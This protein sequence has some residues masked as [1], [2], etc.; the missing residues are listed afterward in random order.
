MIH[1]RLFRD[2]AKGVMENLNE[3]EMV[4]EGDVMKSLGL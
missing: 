4:K 3:V 1:R 2:D